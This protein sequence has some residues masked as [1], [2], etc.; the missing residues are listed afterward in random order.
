MAR[1]LEARSASPL[2]PWGIGSRA[3]RGRL[4]EADPG[5]LN[6]QTAMCSS[7]TPAAWASLIPPELSAAGFPVAS[8]FDAVGI[9][10]A[11]REGAEAMYVVGADQAEVVVAASLGAFGEVEVQA[12]AAEEGDG[13]Q[14][15]E[16]D[17]PRFDRA[18]VDPDGALAGGERVVDPGSQVPGDVTAVGCTADP[19]APVPAR[20]AGLVAG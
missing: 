2:S 5:P 11:A 14:S 8:V 1:R 15:G 3:S 16:D 18:S 19:G 10:E 4:N 6:H 17:G 7:I 9:L 13:V 12:L 20:V